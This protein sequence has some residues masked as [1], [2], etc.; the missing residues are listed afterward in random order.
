[1]PK[2]SAGLL[3]EPSSGY[4]Q[5][6]MIGSDSTGGGRDT[7]LLMKGVSKNLQVYDKT[8]T[9]SSSLCCYNEVKLINLDPTCSL[10]TQV[11]YTEEHLN[12]SIKLSRNMSGQVLAAQV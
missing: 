5:V 7:V 9:I 6:I 4:K 3:S 1:M 10:C 12:V 2:T 11:M 8:I